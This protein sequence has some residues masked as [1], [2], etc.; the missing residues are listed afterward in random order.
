M[1]ILSIVLLPFIFFNLHAIHG[2]CYLVIFKMVAAF[3]VGSD[4]TVAG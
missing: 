1:I 4:G 3:R 2:G